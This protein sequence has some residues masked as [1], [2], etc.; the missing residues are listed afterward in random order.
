LAFPASTA[1]VDIRLITLDE[2]LPDRSIAIR[3][4]TTFLRGPNVLFRVCNEAE[5]WSLLDSVYAKEY[6]N[7]GSRCSIWLQLANGCRYTTGTIP[8]NYTTLF[9]SGWQY[10]EWCIE[11]AEEV[12]P[13]WVVPPMLLK[14]FYHLG[15][16]PRCCWLTLGAAIRLAHVNDLDLG[17]KDSPVSSK[18]E[19][20]RWQEVWRAMITFDT[21]DIP[22]PTITI[23]SST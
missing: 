8:E 3:R 9:E 2:Q 5:S 10:L 18:E 21:Y 23:Y 15:S 12:A 1:G 11:Q 4:L 19:F 16:K 22:H 13:L 20:E 14:C 17:I 7:H 6:I